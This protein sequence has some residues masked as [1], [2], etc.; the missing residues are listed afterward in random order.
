[1]TYRFIQ[2]M[3]YG[4]LEDD[5]I[6]KF[7]VHA[8]LLDIRKTLHAFVAEIIFRGA[9]A[10]IILHDCFFVLICT[11]VIVLNKKVKPLL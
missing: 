5:Y 6:N 1:M 9:D 3:L 11:V 2:P 8:L 10:I 4:F 7:G